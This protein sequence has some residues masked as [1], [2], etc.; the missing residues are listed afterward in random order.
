MSA[1]GF[2][3]NKFMLPDSEI[4]KNLIASKNPNMTKGDINLMVDGIGGEGE[5]SDV[6]KEMDS[7]SEN[8]DTPI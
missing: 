6:I 8:A 4:A 5:Q 7:L 3:M 2:D 1:P